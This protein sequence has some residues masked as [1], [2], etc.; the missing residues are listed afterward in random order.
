MCGIASRLRWCVGLDFIQI[1]QVMVN[2]EGSIFQNILKGYAGSSSGISWL[3]HIR[4]N[5]V[6]SKQHTLGLTQDVS[7][8]RFRESTARYTFKDWVGS[9]TSPGIDTR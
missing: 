3:L 8:F 1:H 5:V 6:S 4:P 7:F 2:F 9:F